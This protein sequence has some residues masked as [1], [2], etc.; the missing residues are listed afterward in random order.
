MDFLQKTKLII[1][2]SILRKRILFVFFALVIFR[3]L[4]NIPI[5]AASGARLDE[6][7][8]GN[9]A[10]GFLNVI[11]G[12]GL[13]AVSI[14]MLGV[15]PYITAS[16]IMQL[17]TMMSSKLK[18]L[19]H[20]EGE[21]GRMRFTQYSR[22]ISVILAAIQAYGFL[23]LL[24]RQGIIDALAPFDL[25]TNIFVITGGSVLLMWLGELITEYGIGNGVSLIIFGGIVAGLPQTLNRL[26]FTFDP[27][28]IPLYVMSLVV[29]VVIV[30]AVVVITEGERP[31]PVTYAKRVR[32]SKMYGG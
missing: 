1:Q 13:S 22:R 19:Y 18:A 3:F 26:I 24:E 31:I 21:A 2:D 29:A 10:L 6:L 28:R 17:L 14:V 4:A 9:Q 11:T 23:I 16:I 25:V 8:A 7:L 15:G 27:S 32:G 20:E 12:G 5:P 30:W